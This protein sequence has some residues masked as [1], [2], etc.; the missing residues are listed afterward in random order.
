MKPGTT[1]AD[2]ISFSLANHTGQGFGG[3]LGLKTAD[4][5][6]AIDQENFASVQMTREEFD[7]GLRI[8]V[9]V[10]KAIKDGDRYAFNHQ[11]EE[12]R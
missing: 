9:E 2:V 4:E 7:C 3:D 5:L 12:H 10:R 8:L 11:T 6:W 1:P